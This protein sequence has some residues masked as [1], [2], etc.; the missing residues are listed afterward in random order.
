[1]KNFW[2]KANFLLI[3]ILIINAV[4][5]PVLGSGV[6]LNTNRCDLHHLELGFNELSVTNSDQ[7]TN[8]KYNSIISLNRKDALFDD[9]LIK[10]LNFIES[11]QQCDV[12]LIK[13]III[14]KNEISKSER[15][16]LID[17]VF[18]EYEIINNYNIIPGVYME[19]NPKELVSRKGLLE[20]KSVLKKVYKSR[21]YSSPSFQEQFPKTSALNKDSYPNWWIPAVG[22]ESLKY[23]GSGVRVA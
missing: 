19:C 23:N 17:S 2:R 20:D 5:S 14:F 11:S 3:N 9:L 16:K 1:M 6:I 21:F 7:V 18:D 10:E 22:A 15:I 13:I 8:E 12:T 4:V